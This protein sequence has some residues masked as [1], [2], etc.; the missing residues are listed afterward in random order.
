MR[1]ETSR[2]QE[3]RKGKT[4]RAPW[5][6]TKISTLEKPKDRELAS[7][8]Q[9]TQERKTTKAARTKETEKQAK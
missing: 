2:K 1:G 6:K 9:A 5:R 3:L 7:R 8:L 4:R